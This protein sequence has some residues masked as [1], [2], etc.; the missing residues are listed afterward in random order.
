MRRVAT[1]VAIMALCASPVWAQAQPLSLNLT[2]NGSGVVVVQERDNNGTIGDVTDD[3]TTTEQSEVSGRV[4]L[5]FSRTEAAMKLSAT[6][7][8]DPDEWV[9]LSNLTV[10]DNRIS[11]ERRRLIWRTRVVIDRRT[12][13]VEISGPGLAFSGTCEKLPDESEARKF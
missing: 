6:M 2:C 10:D 1:W 13:E 8:G 7:G 9:P 4:K 3:K 11:A 5:R 12:G